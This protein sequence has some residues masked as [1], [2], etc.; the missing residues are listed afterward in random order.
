MHDP[1]F[2]YMTTYRAMA[3]GTTTTVVWYGTIIAVDMGCTGMYYDEMLF[4]MRRSH[5]GDGYIAGCGISCSAFD[6]RPMTQ[7]SH[8]TRFP[9]ERHSGVGVGV[10]QG[11]TVR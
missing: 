3:N 10:A 8:G 1:L 9:F 5:A 6:G 7:W 11:K 2:Q 4:R